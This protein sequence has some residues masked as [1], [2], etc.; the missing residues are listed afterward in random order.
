M[1]DEYDETNAPPADSSP[2]PELTAD[3]QALLEEMPT[4]ANVGQSRRTHR[5]WCTE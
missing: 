2:A 5:R 3:E 1:T 4:L